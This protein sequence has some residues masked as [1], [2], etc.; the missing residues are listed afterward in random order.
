MSFLDKLFGRKKSA[1]TDVSET[2]SDAVGG[3]L[4]GL[5]VG[6]IVE[7]GVKAIGKEATKKKRPAKKA[8]K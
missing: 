5:A 4:I 3:G 1:P 8:P 7:E 2:V 6:E